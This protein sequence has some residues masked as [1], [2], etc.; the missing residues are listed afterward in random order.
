MIRRLVFLDVNPHC[1][2]QMLGRTFLSSTRGQIQP[3]RILETAGCGVGC[4]TVDERTGDIIVVRE[5]AIYYYSPG[6]RGPCYAYEGPKTL[7]DTFR[8]YVV[9]VSPSQSIRRA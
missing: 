7:V 6:G 2:S 4:L 8:S 9:L 3:Q 5:D 1:I